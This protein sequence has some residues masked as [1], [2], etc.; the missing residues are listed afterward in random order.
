MPV[1]VAERGLGEAGCV[2]IPP[3]NWDTIATPSALPAVYDVEVPRKE[4]RPE[5]P[6]MI[7]ALV[8]QNHLSILH[9]G[10]RGFSRA[11][12]APIFVIPKTESKCLFIV[13]CTLGNRAHKGAMLRMILPN[14]HTLRHKLLMWA[15]MPRG[16]CPD[17][18]MI[19]LDLTNRY[20]SFL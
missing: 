13:N 20:F 6:A 2:H 5:E 7:R 14:L 3:K 8:R 10:M 17:R 19:K 18:Y 4:L 11:P 16:R 12:S 9:C 1:K 15:A